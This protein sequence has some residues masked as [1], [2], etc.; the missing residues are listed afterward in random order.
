MDWT[1]GIVSTYANK[2]IS[3]AETI[4]TGTGAQLT[5]GPFTLSKVPIFMESLKIRYTV[6]ST[7]Y[8]GTT[9]ALGVITGTYISSGSVTEAGV[10]NL[11]F[12]TAPDNGSTIQAY[13]YKT[14]GVLEKLLDFCLGNRYEE[15]VGTGNGTLVDFSVTLSNT[16]TALGQCRVRFRISGVDYECWD[17]GEGKFSH[18]YIDYDNS[19]LNNATGALVLKFKQAISNSYVI[20]ALYVTPNINGND[21]IYLRRE[22][23]KKSD[24]TDAFS[25]LF[26]QECVIKNSG[27]SYKE[28]HCVGI[29]EYQYIAGNAWNW[30]LNFYKEWVPANESATCPW[31]SNSSFTGKSSYDATWNNFSVHNSV[32]FKDDVIKYWFIV[33]KRRIIVI[34]RLANS[35]YMSCYLGGIRRLCAPSNYLYPQMIEGGLQGNISF[36]STSIYGV[37]HASNVYWQSISPDGLCINGDTPNKHEPGQSLLATGNIGKDKNDRILIFPEY[38]IQDQNLGEIYKRN[39]GE[40]DGLYLCPS[41]NVAS[42]DIVSIDGTNYL[43]FQNVHRLT[44]LDY[45]VVRLD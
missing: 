7:L 20:K 37:G 11:T 29:R 35:S 41:S 4:G 22:N 44:Y 15:T 28:F 17:N 8:Y 21:W 25:G 34:A 26:L 43:V 39:L 18:Q 5:F 12:S 3:V 40:I 19:S 10:I 13:E 32:A 45:S 23:S 24:G 6:G 9:S 16:P 36:N 30:N 2:V 33:N 38:I 1:T 14:K 31:N 27:L 42:E